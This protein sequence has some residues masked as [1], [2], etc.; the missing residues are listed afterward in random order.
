L[1]FLDFQFLKTNFGLAKEFLEQS[2]N[3]FFVIFMSS[4]AEMSF[5]GPQTQKV[6]K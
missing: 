2:R 5:W 4:Y 6:N 3:A 1:D